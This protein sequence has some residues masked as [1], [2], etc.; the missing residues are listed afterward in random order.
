MHENMHIYTHIFTHTYMYTCTC[1]NMHTYM[2]MCIHMH[3]HMSTYT[4]MHVYLH[5]HICMK[6]CTH[7]CVHVH[8]HIC[9]LAH[10]HTHIHACTNTNMHMALLSTAHSQAQQFY[11]QC[12]SF[13]DWRLCT[14]VLPTLSLLGLETA[15]PSA[16]HHWVFFS[17][18]A[19]LPGIPTSLCLLKGESYY[20][21]RYQIRLHLLTK[22]F[23]DH[24]LPAQSK[25]SLHHNSFMTPF[26]TF[27]PPGFVALYFH[28]RA[29]SA[30]QWLD[31]L[32]SPGLEQSWIVLVWMCSHTRFLRGNGAQVND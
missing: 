3:I 23:L 2:E 31:C 14:L 32:C 17:C 5:M 25:L 29:R 30:R 19:F 6:T 21:L 11:S 8:T 10:A 20:P 24:H 12:F 26:S 18:W 16:S 1:T 15:Y 4:H 28:H 7:A 22:A 9:A 27:Q 13:W